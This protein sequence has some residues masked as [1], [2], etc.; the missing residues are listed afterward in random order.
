MK[1]RYG[2]GTDQWVEMD[3]SDYRRYL[4][5]VDEQASRDAAADMGEYLEFE[6]IVEVSNV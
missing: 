1:V 6:R 4:A 3:P 2:S 5:G